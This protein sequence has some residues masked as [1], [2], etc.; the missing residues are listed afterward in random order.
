MYKTIFDGHVKTLKPFLSR[1]FCKSNLQQGNEHYSS[2]IPYLSV[3]NLKCERRLFDSILDVRTP[4]E[5]EEDRVPGA[6]S[7]PVLS[8]EQRHV[9]G[10]HYS[11]SKFEARKQGAALISQNISQ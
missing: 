11:R 9:I 6:L 3:R 10:M 2:A 7:I 5:F 4:A 1:Q 8:D